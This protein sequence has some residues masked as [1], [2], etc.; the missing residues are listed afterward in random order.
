M[1]VRKMMTFTL[2]QYYKYNIHSIKYANWLLISINILL[3]NENYSFSNGRV[4][5]N[6]KLLGIIKWMLS[7]FWG[8]FRHVCIQSL[9]ASKMFGSLHIYFGTLIYTYSYDMYPKMNNSFW[10]ASCALMKFIFLLQFFF[11]PSM[12]QIVP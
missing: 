8:F 10:N 11:T 1:M 9:E 7:T 3:F 12:T 5:E 2:I 6:D 4:A